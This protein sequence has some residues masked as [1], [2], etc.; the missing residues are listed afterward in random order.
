MRKKSNRLIVT[1]LLVPVLM[2][3][4]AV[5]TESGAKV[6]LVD[7]GVPLPS[8]CKFIVKIDE[9]GFDNNLG[10]AHIEARY[11]LRNKA[12]IKGANLVQ[13]TKE[14]QSFY[15]RGWFVS[16]NAYSCDYSAKAA[17]A[18]SNEVMLKKKRCETKG[19]TLKNDQCVID[20]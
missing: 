16:G 8:I 20:I 4:C 6:R 5:L 13:L 14:S 19:G 11:D 15:P 7:G 9:D 10:A 1:A 18:A 12:A 2:S 3:G 17:Q